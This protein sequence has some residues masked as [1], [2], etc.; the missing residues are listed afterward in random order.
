M[1]CLQ[2]HGKGLFK[3]ARLQIHRSL[4]E[5]SPTSTTDGYRVDVIAACLASSVSAL[6]IDTSQLCISKTH[7]RQV[8]ST[9]NETD[10]NWTHSERHR[11]CDHRHW[12]T[13]Q[14]RILPTK[15]NTAAAC[16]PTKLSMP[17]NC[18]TGLDTPCN[19][20][21]LSQFRVQVEKATF[22][23]SKVQNL[24]RCKKRCTRQKL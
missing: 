23:F 5:D 4:Q 9:Q 24:A 1:W 19:V 13:R 18:A 14:G 21:T 7:Y 8:T 20:M 15:G 11:G 22:V 17:P 12:P 2:G 3:R 16:K 6:S 10:I